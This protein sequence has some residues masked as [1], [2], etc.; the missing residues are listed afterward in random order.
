MS[1]NTE[2]IETASVARSQILIWRLLL[3][4]S[5]PDYMQ[6]KILSNKPLN[7]HVPDPLPQ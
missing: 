3:L 4:T 2:E 7:G 6:I 5:G 1:W